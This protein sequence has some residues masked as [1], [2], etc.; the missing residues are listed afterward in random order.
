VKY[1]Y[2]EPS[3]NTIVVENNHLP[4]GKYR[5]MFSD[6]DTKVS[7]VAENVNTPR[8][9]FIP[10]TEYMD[11]NNV[12]YVDK[13]DLLTRLGAEFFTSFAETGSVSGFSNVIIYD[14]N[15]NPIDE[16]N[17]LSVD[18]G[19]DNNDFSYTIETTSG[20]ITGARSFAVYA[21]KGFSGTFDG[22]VFD[23]YMEAKGAHSKGGILNDISYTIISGELL[24]ATI[25]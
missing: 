3:N 8:S 24:I 17:P 23:E 20:V 21:K 13:N 12:S 4:A 11:K 25:K 14:R 16:N 9:A 18:Y 10:I 5:L 19:F 6:F 22:Q 15:E 2:F 1:L 7:V